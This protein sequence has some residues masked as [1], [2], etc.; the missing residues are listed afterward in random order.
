MK[1]LLIEESNVQPVSAPVTVCGDIHGQFHDLRKL[2]QTGGDVPNTSYVFMVSYPHL[3][4]SCLAGVALVVLA[5]GNG[6]VRSDLEGFSSRET[7]WIGGFTVW[8]RSCYC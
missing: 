5:L 3:S 1:E 2:F 6:N 4:A 8:R 7:S